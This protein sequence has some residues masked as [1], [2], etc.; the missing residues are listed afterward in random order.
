M[1]PSLSASR[2]NAEGYKK[3]GPLDLSVS[4]S[5]VRVGKMSMSSVCKFL[6]STRSQ[7]G[8]ICGVTVG[9]LLL[10]VGAVSSEYYVQIV[11]EVREVFVKAVFQA[12]FQRLTSCRK[13]QLI[14]S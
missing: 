9:I 10:F 11:S 7:R 13:L 4:F 2:R 14:S 3:R 1:L 12:L 8:L 5:I 6:H